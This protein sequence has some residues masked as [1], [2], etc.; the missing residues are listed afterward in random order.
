MAIEAD[1]VTGRNGRTPAGVGR[2]GGRRLHA[3]T[4]SFTVGPAAGTLTVSHTADGVLVRVEIRMSKQGSTLYGLLDVL[5]ATLTRGLAC[6]VPLVELLRDL[7]GTRFEPAGMT[8]DAQIGQ[9]SS[10]PDYVGRRLALDFLPFE[11]RQELGVL[12]RE[13]RSTGEQFVWP[14]LP[15]I[16]P[17]LPRARQG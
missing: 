11:Q 8:E 5:S 9:A 1:A 3:L 12:A 7:L 2:A 10:V 4:R 17:L 15:E 16:A 6:G 13:E 14:V